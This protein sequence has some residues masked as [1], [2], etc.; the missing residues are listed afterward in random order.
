MILV[1]A[2]IAILIAMLMPSVHRMRETGKQVQCLSKQRQIG[3]AMS[4]YIKNEDQ[5]FPSH[6]NST[7]TSGWFTLIFGYV[8]SEPDI[9]RCAS[10]TVWECP[11]PHGFGTPHEIVL[12]RAED[13]KPQL[14]HHYMTYGYNGYWLG[15]YPYPHSANPMGKNFCRLTDLRNPGEVLVTSDSELKNAADH[16]AQS[17]WYPFRTLIN[18]GVSEVH[19][20]G[21]NVLFADGHVKLYDDALIN[22]YPEYQG[23]W[24]PDPTRWK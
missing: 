20:G 11:G 6:R 24:S 5:V 7:I 8:D 15:A 13:D 10:R 21:G 17:I 4:L 9:F 1:V 12:P 23:W 16:W 14:A 3:L 2:I 19:Q 22:N 18:E